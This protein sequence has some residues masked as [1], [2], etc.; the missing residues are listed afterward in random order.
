MST[1][2][3]SQP[4]SDAIAQRR[5]LWPLIT[6]TQQ[7][8]FFANRAPMNR[9]FE[10]FGLG[11]RGLPFAF[12]QANLYEPETVSGAKICSR[13]PYSSDTAWDK[14]LL[15]VAN[16][17]YLDRSANRQIFRVN[18]KGREAFQ[19]FHAALDEELLALTGRLAPAFSAD[20][21][22]NIATR[23]EQVVVAAVAAADDPDAAPH[24]RCFWQKQQRNAC[25]LHRIDYLIDC[26][27]AFRD[28][29]HLASFQ[30]LDLPGYTWELFTFIW[31]GQLTDI[32]DLADRLG[33]LRGYDARSYH[34]GLMQLV[35]FGWV[36]L[37]EGG[38]YQL[39]EEGLAVRIQAENETDK[40]FY[41]P[42]LQLD[43]ETTDAL[44]ADLKALG[45]AVPGPLQ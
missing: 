41:Q 30:H 40:V 32:V 4:L 19:Q 18:D 31:R 14:L 16:A 12:I 39:T 25:T 20:Q 11:Q 1:N 2:S 17:G 22:D 6:A 5:D 34:Q 23:L 13:F 36:Q 10:T 3:P 43:D 33:P 27:N 21:L 24:L 28:D 15:Q 44:R 8:I 26:L 45:Q 35:G 38:P 9:L 29:A 42:W 37:T 7:K